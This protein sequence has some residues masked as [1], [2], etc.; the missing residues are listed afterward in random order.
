MKPLVSVRPPAFRLLALA[1]KKVPVVINKF[2]PLQVPWQFTQ[3]LLHHIPA[4]FDMLLTAGKFFSGWSAYW[5]SCKGRT[6]ANSDVDI[7]IYC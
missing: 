7:A 4:G 3:L 1:E 6:T 2:P 5:V